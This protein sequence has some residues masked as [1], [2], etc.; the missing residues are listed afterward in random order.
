MADVEQSETPILDSGVLP[1]QRKKNSVLGFCFGV[2]IGI[3]FLVVVIKAS[4]TESQKDIAGFTYFIALGLAVIIHELGHLIAGWLVG[5][6][7]ASISVGPFILGKEHG[8]IKIHFRQGLGALG[9]A[10]VHIDRI[11]RLRRRFLIFII[12]GPA[13]NLLSAALVVV[14]VKYAFPSVRGSWLM[15][16]IAGFLYLSLFLGVIGFLPLWSK[17]RSDGSRIWMLLTSYKKS[18]RLISAMALINQTRLGVP[19]KSWKCTWLKAVTAVRDE[20]FDEFTANW[21]AFLAASGR[22]DV[23]TL[24]THLER[25]LELAYMLPVAKRDE[26]AREAGIYAAWHGNNAILAERWLAQMKYPK[27]IVKIMQ[28]RID[29]VMAY[30]RKD[31]GN[32]FNGMDEGSVFIESLPQSPYQEMLKQS[33]LEW[34]D[35]LREKQ[36][37]TVTV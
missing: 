7:F 13:S 1:P 17:S 26:I 19:L 11:R 33:W 35:E 2:V 36:N 12:G 21:I 20:S 32:A 15:P 9:F 8:K 30:A 25:C 34:K 3:L 28:I 29:I 22:K 31:F 6:H 14:L 18:R 24:R 16:V 23:P 10:G 37:Q 5:F 4:S 27:Q